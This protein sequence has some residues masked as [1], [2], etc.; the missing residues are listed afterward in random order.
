MS[1]E[2]V[3]LDS[4][5]NP[6]ERNHLYFFPRIYHKGITNRVGYNVGLL[7]EIGEGYIQIQDEETDILVKVSGRFVKRKCHKLTPMTK[8]EV[9]SRQATYQSRLEILSCGHAFMELDSL[10]KWRQ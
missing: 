5:N 6:L 7:K 3:F 8:Q 1:E 2:Q 4:M 9:E 10:K